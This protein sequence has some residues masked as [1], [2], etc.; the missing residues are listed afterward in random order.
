M[1]IRLHTFRRHSRRLSLLV[2]LAVCLQL[3]AMSVGNPHALKRL[4]L[5]Q[6]HG[7]RH[8]GAAVFH[9]HHGGSGGIGVEG[10]GRPARDVPA[11]E[12][13]CPFCVSSANVL[14]PVVV[15]FL[16]PSEPAANV[17]LPMAAAGFQPSAPDSR[18]APK[19]APPVS[20]A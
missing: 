7:Q 3:A 11:A 2:L 12:P 1:L 16:V 8:D 13:H 18:H 4:A 19:R 14:P 5:A 10:G 17:F 6:C 20:F 15:F 9:A